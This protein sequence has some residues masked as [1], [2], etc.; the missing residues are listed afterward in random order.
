MVI[1]E[2]CT[3]SG[4]ITIFTRAPSGKAGRDTGEGPTPPP[5]NPGDDPIDDLAKL[6]FVLE[7]QLGLRQAAAA[8]GEDRLGPVDHDFAD[9]RVLEQGLE[10]TQTEDV[11][12]DQ[13]GRL[14]AVELRQLELGLFAVLVGELRDAALDHVAADRV[15]VLAEGRD[16]TLMD[17]PLDVVDIGDTGRDVLRLDDQAGQTRG[18]RGLALVRLLRKLAFVEFVNEQHRVLLVSSAWRAVTGGVTC[19]R[20]PPPRL[21]PSHPPFGPSGGYPA[22][23]SPLAKR[24]FRSIPAQQAEPRRL[25]RL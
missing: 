25:T 18:R 4:G 10:G 11:V 8:L 15:R 12:H 7:D 24:A 5:S 16:Q 13:L 21:P 9:L 2:P 19:A 17:G 1:L 3:A 14:G 23:A 22:K 20:P 6:A